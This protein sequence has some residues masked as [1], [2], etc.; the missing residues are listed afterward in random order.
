MGKN[1][2]DF[3]YNRQPFYHC[4]QEV[5]FTLTQPLD[6]EDFQK[7]LEIA[8]KALKTKKGGPSIYVPDTLDIGEWGEPEPGDPSD[9]M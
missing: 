2:E 8:L 6:R 1:K 9:L 5:T 3:Q 4:A 7:V